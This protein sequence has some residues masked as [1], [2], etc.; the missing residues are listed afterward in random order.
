MKI[1]E[2]L[3]LLTTFQDLEVDHHVSFAILFLSLTGIAFQILLEK[4]FV[5]FI[6]TQR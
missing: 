5:F 4:F 6:F 1:A 3:F 2:S